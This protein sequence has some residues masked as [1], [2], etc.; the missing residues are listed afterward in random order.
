MEKSTL[1]E[2]LNTTRGTDNIALWPPDCWVGMLTVQ[3]VK[4]FLDLKSQNNIYQ[5]RLL[6]NIKKQTFKRIRMFC[7]IPD[8]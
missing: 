7:G 5:H 4:A 6:E 1:A 8:S 2:W 3:V